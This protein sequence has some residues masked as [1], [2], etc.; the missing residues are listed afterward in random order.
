MI[1]E[2]T[3]NVTLIDINDELPTITTESNFA[4]DENL[5]GLLGIVLANDLDATA[6]LTFSIT[7]DRAESPNGVSLP[8]PGSFG[9]H[10]AFMVEDLAEGQHPG[11]RSAS[12]RVVIPL[13]R[14][15]T[16]TIYAT[17]AVTGLL[18]IL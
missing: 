2:C 13:D 17:I 18:Q 3:V 10:F 11:N 15:E 16:Q 9:A 4:I 1:S 7:V 14:E 6:N 5:E 12:I 8:N